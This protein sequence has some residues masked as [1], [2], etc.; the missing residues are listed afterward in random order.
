MRKVLIISTSLRGNSNSDILARECEKGAR[1]AGLD[2]EYVSL[3]GKDIKYCIG[4]LSCQKTGKC[5]LK[6]GVT[7][8]MAKA[9]E[10]EVIVYATP[11]YYYEMCGQMKTLLDRFN[12][13][14][15]GDYNFR[16]IYLIATAAD[17]GDATFDKAYS[18]LQGWVDCFDK[19]RLKGKVVAGGVDEA[20]SVNNFV[21]IKNK[22]YELG[23][24]L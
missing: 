5:V 3:K 15:S 19:A 18:G 22:A 14:Y 6:D 4:C 9:K 1:D 21:D 17:D 16:D 11:I 13:L 10:A 12:P 24:N 2:T 20:G 23:K 8:I 7:D